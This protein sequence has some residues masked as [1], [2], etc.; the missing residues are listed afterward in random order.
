M[1]DK[2]GR[3]LLHGSFATHFTRMKKLNPRNE[4]TI[5]LPPQK[6]ALD[7]KKKK[8]SA[9]HS[10]WDSPPVRNSTFSSSYLQQLKK[11]TDTTVTFLRLNSL[12]IR[13]WLSTHISSFQNRFNRIPTLSSHQFSS[14]C[15]QVKQIA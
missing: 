12:P 2:A 11:Q 8:R 1:S 4:D 6:I 5:H 9:T 10:V 7:R 13:M 15:F 14:L 3:R